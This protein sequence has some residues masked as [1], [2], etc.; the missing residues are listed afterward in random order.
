[1]GGITW[2]LRGGGGGG[3]RVG[4][5]HGEGQGK[6]NTETGTETATEMETETG[7]VATKS[8]KHQVYTSNGRKI[9]LDI[10]SVTI[11]HGLS[12]GIQAHILIGES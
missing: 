7:R 1:M 6:G 11:S 5:G 12:I 9:Y 8:D 10:W 3:V 2:P 4:V